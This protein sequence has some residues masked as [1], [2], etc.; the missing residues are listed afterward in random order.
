MTTLLGSLLL[1]VS[2]VAGMAIGGV[3]L[4]MLGHRRGSRGQFWLGLAMLAAS[5]LLVGGLLWWVF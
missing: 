4:M 1:A 5:V 3:V 2:S